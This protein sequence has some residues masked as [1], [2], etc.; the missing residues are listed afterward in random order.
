MTIKPKKPSGKTTEI[1]KLRWHLINNL[2][3]KWVVPSSWN[4]ESFVAKMKK[5]HLV[6]GIKVVPWE[7]GR[8]QRSVFSS[9]KDTISMAAAGRC[10]ALFKAQCHEDGYSASALPIQM[11]NISS[12]DKKLAHHKSWSSIYHVKKIKLSIWRLTSYTYFWRTG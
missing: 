3:K 1:Q 9:S 7:G 5:K 2:T 4:S 11:F 8:L 12:V 10:N 6:R